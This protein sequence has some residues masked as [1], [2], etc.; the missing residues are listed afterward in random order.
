MATAILLFQGLKAQTN[1]QKG[2]ILKTESDTLFGQ[3]D[4]K[5]YYLNSQFC[6]FKASGSESVTR[7][8]PGEIFGYRFTDG[9]YYISGNIS[10]DGKQQLIFL[11]YLIKGRLNIYYFQEKN[12]MPH[13]Y[14]LKDTLPMQELKYS[15]EE[16]VVDGIAVLETKKSY[17]GIL[18][19][20]TS[21]CPAVKNIIPGMDEPDQKKLINFAQKYHK[22]TCPGESCIIYGKKTPH[23]IKLEAYAGMQNYFHSVLFNFD[24]P[25]GVFPT[26]GFNIL[27]QQAQRLENIYIGL[28]FSNIIKSDSL[29]SFY[30]I[31]F[32]ISY[33]NSK[34]G[35]SPQITYEFDINKGFTAQAL[36][37]GLKYQVK[38]LSFSL[39]AGLNTLLVISPYGASL[40]FGLMYD[41]R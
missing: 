16:K 35:F 28:G 22:L 18:N 3:I 26:Y 13:Y 32:S 14:A 41:F 4:N 25:K 36:K 38:N 27:F 40:N 33:I 39:N 17:V 30:R 7:F 2:Y 21:D 11:E 24:P 19:Y 23:Q 20:L 29:E 9:K 10:M 37:V 34:K 5:D 15:Q 12:L 6:D 31:P 8:Q 1:F